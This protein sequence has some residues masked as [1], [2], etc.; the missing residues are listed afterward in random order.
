MQSTKGTTGTVVCHGQGPETTGVHMLLPPFVF[1]AA[2]W[3]RLGCEKMSGPMSFNELHS[4][5][6]IWTLPFGQPTILLLHHNNSPNGSFF[7][8]ELHHTSSYAE[9]PQALVTD[10]PNSRQGPQALQPTQNQQVGS[11]AFVPQIKVL[12]S[13]FSMSVR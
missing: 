7:Q 12:L 4:W 6:V 10:Q 9:L 13:Y 3:G 2:Q 1:T 8:R 5:V 11:Q